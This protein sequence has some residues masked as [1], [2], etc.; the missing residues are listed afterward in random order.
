MWRGHLRERATI[1]E[2]TPMSDPLAE[3]L[4]ER[5]LY[6]SAGNRR[7]PDITDKLLRIIAKDEKKRRKEEEEA[8]K[9]KSDGD[10]GFKMPVFN[11]WQLI[12]L[13]IP[14]G[15]GWAFV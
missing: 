4:L 10:K 6:S 9:K 13:S 8:K 2:I 1:E 12:V 7:D 3:R 15:W 11:I 14:L 5:I